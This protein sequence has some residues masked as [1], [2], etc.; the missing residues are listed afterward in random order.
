MKHDC[1]VIDYCICSSQALEPDENCPIHGY[2]IWPPRCMHCGKFMKWPHPAECTDHEWIKFENEYE[3]WVCRKCGMEGI[4]FPKETMKKTSPH[5]CS[6]LRPWM[7][8][9][10]YKIVFGL[11]PAIELANI[12]EFEYEH[13]RMQLD[14]LKKYFTSANEIEVDRA[15]IRMEDWKKITEWSEERNEKVYKRI[16]EKRKRTREE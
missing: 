4:N 8:I 3:N 9:N 6:Q 15:V 11:C 12:L 5:D 13:L 16:A 10:D 2:G 7:K 14:E 1:K